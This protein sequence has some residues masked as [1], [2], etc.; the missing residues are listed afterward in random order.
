MC[1]TMDGS[2]AYETHIVLK[3]KCIWIL[4]LLI[5]KLCQWQPKLTETTYLVPVTLAI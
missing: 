3:L 4:I 1:Y 5:K 2:P